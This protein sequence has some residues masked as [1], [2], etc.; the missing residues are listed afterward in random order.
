MFVCLYVLKC[1]G[2]P[3]WL[4]LYFAVEMVDSCVFAG[5]WYMEGIRDANK[6]IVSK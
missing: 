6:Q 1:C 3:D 4:S 2:V 5:F